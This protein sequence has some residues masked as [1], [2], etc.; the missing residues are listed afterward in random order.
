MANTSDHAFQNSSSSELDMLKSLT[1]H[2]I[3]NPLLW[4][5]YILPC[6]LNG[7]LMV[8]ILKDPLKCFRSCSSYL[9]FNFGLFGFLPLFILITHILALSHNDNLYLSV[10]GFLFGFYN[11]L[12]SV[13]LLAVDR[14]VLAC[15]PL[16][17]SIIVTKRRV[18]YCVILSWILS[19]TLTVVSFVLY[20]SAI[21]VIIATQIFVF[22]LL[23]IFFLLVI[24]IMVLNIKAWMAVAHCAINVQSLGKQNSSPFKN[25][26][27]RAKEKRLKNER[28]FCKVVL[29][30]HLNLMFLILPQ[31]LIISMKVI[32]I[33]C[34][35]CIGELHNAA[36]FQ[37]YIF[38]LFYTT[39][40]VIHIAFIPKYRKSCRSLFVNVEN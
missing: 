19:G 32:N 25:L 15:R 40:P 8:T 37:I 38:P 35:L 29:L 4:I 27:Q 3:R 5:D 23:P 7:V 11:T 9:V 31:V 2:T 1:W 13:F 10:Y 24:A 6:S 17:Y 14:Y 22:T 28:R 18:L 30:L 26:R 34:K 21:D 33:W 20:H 36:L 16:W 12:F 39:T